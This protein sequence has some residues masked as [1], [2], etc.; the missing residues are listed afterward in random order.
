MVNPE[1][2]TGSNFIRNIINEDNASNKYEGRVH[3]RFPPEPN[4][5]LH[6][7][8]AKSICLN[9]GLALEYG[10]QC[11][12]RFDD[13]NPV[14]E[15]P[16]YV[17][18]IQKDVKWLGFDWQ[19]RLFNASDYFDKFYE[20]A[21]KLI[22][23]DKAYVDSQSADEIR[24]NRGTLTE[25]GRNSSYR[26]RSVAENLTLLRGM[27]DGK[28]DEGSH[29]LRAK[30]DMTSPNINMR[31]PAIYRIRMAE[32]HATGK[33]WCIYP[34]YDFAHCISDA[35]ER[36]T[37]S[38]CTLEFEDHRPLYDWF[39]DNCGFAQPRPKQIEFARLDLTYTVT[40]KRKLK[41]LVTGGHV[42]S[43]DDPRMPTISGMRRRGFRPAALRDFCERI[44]VAKAANIV[45]MGLLE[46]CVR[47]DLETSARRVLGVLQ[48]I[49]LVIEDYPADKVEHIEAPYHP[50]D[51]TFGTRKLPFTREVYIESDD[52][53]ENPPKGYFRLVPGG[54]VRLRYGYIIKCKEVIKDSL[55]K[56]VEIRCS[57]DAD[58]LG[59]NPADGRKVK[60]IIHWVSAS[61]AIPAEVRLYD[62]LFNIA[63][64]GG[65]KEGDYKDH[66]NPESLTT[67]TTA[68]LEPSLEHVTTDQRFQFERLGYF[69]LDQDSTQSKLVFNRT[70]SLRDS[71]AKEQRG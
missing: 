4:G 42:K 68:M 70:V 69:C 27:R 6:I 43:W 49:K 8:H 52:F 71:W 66:F 32:H 57:H 48:P 36:I 59:K 14:A 62:R 63:N 56:I 22:A 5:Y 29:I 40:S 44:G 65:V 33:K 10:G 21:E 9:F 35:L 2:P 61:K 13:T 20:Y 51:A 17:A 26:D 38:I 37:H 1:K 55:G 41:E 3:T 58:T 30:I 34:M 60:G 24:K 46:F 67:V 12:L 23:L 31:D 50:Q 16:E 19:D 47:E 11:N 53:S 39:L 45:D 15:D 7:G 64:P 28:Y 54:E 18:S 25:P